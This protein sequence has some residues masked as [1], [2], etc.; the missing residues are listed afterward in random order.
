MAGMVIVLN[1]IEQRLA[2]HVAAK[3]QKDCEDKGAK[4]LR[5]GPQSDLQS[6]LDGIGAELA[7]CKLMN[8][9]PDMVTDRWPDSDAITRYGDSVDVK[10]TRYPNGRLVM[11][12]H[13]VNKQSDLYALMVGTFPE[14]QMVGVLSAEQVFRPENVRDLG[15]GPCYVIEQEK[16]EQVEELG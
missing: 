16:L 5:M 15:H 10:T 13:K 2:R 11:P 12:L 7:F 1:E 8:V 4:N 3:R 6:H 9:Y 14:Y